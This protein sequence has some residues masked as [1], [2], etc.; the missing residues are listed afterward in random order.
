MGVNPEV[1]HRIAAIASSVFAVMPHSGVVLTFLALTGLNHK[2]SF[3][4]Q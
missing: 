4:Y 2:N 1:I 3:K